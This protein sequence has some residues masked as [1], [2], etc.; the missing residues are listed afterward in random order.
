MGYGE[1]IAKSFSA[2]FFPDIAAMEHGP[3]VSSAPE[4][5]I[6]HRASSLI[7]DFLQDFVVRSVLAAC[8]T[9]SAPEN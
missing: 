4:R 8:P 9:A 2:P 6:V 5:R 1:Q 7:S 3:E